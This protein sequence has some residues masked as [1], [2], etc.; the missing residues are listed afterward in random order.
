M[1]MTHLAL[2][3]LSA[4]FAMQVLSPEN[5][6]LFL[7]LV[8]FGSLAPDL[9]HPDSKLGKRTKILAYLFEHRGFMHS[10]YAF[11]IFFFISYVLFGTSVYLW[12]V[13]LGYLSHLISDSISKEGVM[14]F[15]PLSK[16]RLRGFIR[17]GSMVEYVIFILLFGL[18]VW[19]L[20]II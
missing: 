1:G 2:G 6:I 11:S 3:F 16:A 18:G 14:F 17:T 15:H 8:L 19:Q 13:P 7:V 20:I 5:Q 4:L 9:D 10:I 12:A